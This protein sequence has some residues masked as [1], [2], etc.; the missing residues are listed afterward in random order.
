VGGRNVKA[1]QAVDRK[2]PIGVI[3]GHTLDEKVQV[4]L[5]VEHAGDEK[6]RVE[7]KQDRLGTRG[8]IEVKR[9]QARYERMYWSDGRSG[10]IGKGREEST[11][12]MGG[13]AGHRKGALE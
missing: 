3:A 6:E 12:V 2:R 4:V 13:H 7:A 5:M 9:G 1:P 10:W 8:C 11:G